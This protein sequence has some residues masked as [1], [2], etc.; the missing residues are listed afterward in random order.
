[1]TNGIFCNFDAER[2]ACVLLAHPI[3]AAQVRGVLMLGNN[4]RL[5]WAAPRALADRWR[6]LT[7]WFADKGVFP[8]INDYS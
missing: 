2:D 8:P 4:R 7:E 6:C 3:N 5:E 1:M